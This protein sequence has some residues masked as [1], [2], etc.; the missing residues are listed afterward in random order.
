MRG[1]VDLLGQLTLRRQLVA[2]HE[3][4]D[5][6]GTPDVF[7]DEA[8]HRSVLDRLDAALP[9]RVVLPARLERH[10]LMVAQR[11]L[12]SPSETSE[13]AERRA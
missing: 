5:V 6:D 12:V 3:R 1:D 11:G 2:G 13:A 8:V 4:A 9:V 7:D 10:R